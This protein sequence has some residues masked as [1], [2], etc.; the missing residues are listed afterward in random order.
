[1]LILKNYFPKNLGSI[2]IITGILNLVTIIPAFYIGL[3]KK[4]NNL[5]HHNLFFDTDFDKHA[6]EIYSNPKWPESPLFYL[7]ITSKTFK[8]TAPKG[9]EN[10]FILIP[11]A[12][13]LDDNEDIRNKYFEIVAK[14]FF[15]NWL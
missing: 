9:H 12:T 7:N 1:M 8:H 13:D 5:N 11:I 6:D 3:N 15:N 14:I 2:L 10:C 4:I